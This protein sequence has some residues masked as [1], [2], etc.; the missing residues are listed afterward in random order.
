MKLKFI[1]WSP[2]P[3]CNYKCEYCSQN[4]TDPAIVNRRQHAPDSICDAVIKIM[5]EYKPGKIFIG[6]GEPTLHPRMIEIASETVNAGTFFRMPTNFSQPVER[7][8][9]LSHILKHNGGFSASWHIS[10]CNADKFIEKCIIY[11]AMKHPDAYF[12]CTVTLTDHELDIIK[13]GKDRLNA[14]GI[15]LNIMPTK[16]YRTRKLYTYNEKTKAFIKTLSEDIYKTGVF[17][18]RTKGILC[19]SGYDNFVILG[20]GDVKRCYGIQAEK[21]GNVATGYKLY[22]QPMPCKDDTCGCGIYYYEKCYEYVK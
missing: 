9:E 1:T 21:L 4:H 6:G 13:R 15:K 16:D 8:I 17:I 19:S 20:N 10:Q 18:Q 7:Y 11:N 14:S 2:T 22:D 3:I 5:R 12:V